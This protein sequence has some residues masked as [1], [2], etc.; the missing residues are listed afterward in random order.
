M[1]FIVLKKL[2][3][4]MV[5]EQFVNLLKLLNLTLKKIERLSSVSLTHMR[6]TSY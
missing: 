3:L 4:G 1:M 5:V 2:G 6:W